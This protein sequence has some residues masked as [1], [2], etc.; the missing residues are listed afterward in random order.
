MFNSQPKYTPLLI[1]GPSTTYPPV[2]TEP[3]RSGSPNDQTEKNEPTT[4]YMSERPSVVV[5][6]KCSVTLIFTKE[7]AVLNM[8]I[9]RFHLKKLSNK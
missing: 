2:L 6:G 8:F 3:L 1:E 5:L 9:E 7:H 4:S